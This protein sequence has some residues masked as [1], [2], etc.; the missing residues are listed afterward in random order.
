MDVAATDINPKAASRILTRRVIPINAT[1]GILKSNLQKPQSTTSDRTNINIAQQYRWHR[2]IDTEYNNLRTQNTGLC[3]LSGKSFGEVMDHFIIG[4]DEM[5]LMSEENGNASIIGC[6]DKKKHE[7]VLQDSRTSI[8][9][10]RTGTVSGTT[11]PTIFVL[12]GTAR[13]KSYTDEFLERHGMAKGS[14]IIMT[15]NAYMTDEAWL[16]AS[17]AIVRGYRSLPYIAENKDW[18]M[19]ELMDGFKS[20]ENVLAAHQMRIDHK[21]MSLKEE[22]NT[23]HVNQG[24]DQLTA[25]TDK[26]NAAASLFEQ[27][28]IVKSTTGKSQLDQYDLVQCGM[29]IVRQLEAETWQLSFRRV[30][31]E[32]S[33]RLPFPQWC[34]K[35]R[36]FLRAGELFKDENID[37]TPQQIFAMLPTFW[38]G[39]QPAD[40]KVVMTVIQSH[41]GLYT[42]GCL[43]QLHTECNIPYSHM[44]DLRVCVNIANSHPET[45]D[46][47]CSSLE[48]LRKLGSEDVTATCNIVH[49]SI[50]H[51][52][53]KNI[54]HQ[55]DGLDLFQLVPKTS[56]GNSKLSGMDL[57]DHMIAYRNV[58]NAETDD[59][60]KSVP[61]MPSAELDLAIAH[62]SMNCIQPD[63]S[64]IRRS[65]ILKDAIGDR[66]VRKCAKRK[67]NN[68]ANVV[69]HCT[70]VN[71]KENMLRMK[72]RLEMADSLAE[73]ER[74]EAAAKAEK[75]RESLQKHA[76]KAPGAAKTLEKNGRNNVKT[77]TMAEIESLLYIVYNKTLSGSKL[78]KPDYVRALEKEM[79]G[80]LGLAK[81]T[82]YVD[83]L[84]AE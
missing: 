82:L 40:R 74:S 65:A 3:K 11:G 24:Y 58:N 78:R 28:K 31:L 49:D 51:E 5:C 81:Y 68:I 47:E 1:E 56:E 71:S 67:L 45:L 53:K 46:F 64:Q 52:A 55:N 73:I 2:L 54:T 4:L 36:N 10:V 30:N 62:D 23:S 34:T 63:A 20:H 14:T 83:S 43:E 13:R 48:D 7:R 25:K 18:V 12:S 72:E 35:I 16:E 29:R 42:P 50:I 59:D 22:S 17:K 57:F 44:N 75:A 32:P 69:G 19:L 9:I 6:A 66:A 38:H 60:G 15:E 26:K 27:R 77:L 41:G 76:T 79:N 61:I 39:M 70:V 8:T 33:T 21:I 37:A 84:A 80:E